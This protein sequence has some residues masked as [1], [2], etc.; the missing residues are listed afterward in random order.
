MGPAAALDGTLDA[1]AVA[2]ADGDP[3]WR[4]FFDASVASVLFGP[5]VIGSRSINPFNYIA[6]PSFWG[7]PP[8]SA[9]A[10]TRRGA[11]SESGIA[12]RNG[13]ER[14]RQADYMMMAQSLTKFVI[15]LGGAEKISFIAQ[16]PCLNNI[17]VSKLKSDLTAHGISWQTD[18]CMA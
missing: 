12:A 4:R 16:V 2:A 13:G 8:D 18:N 3:S 11:L 15:A 5:I 9:V 10:G 17:E 14:Q 6:L 1:G 7:T